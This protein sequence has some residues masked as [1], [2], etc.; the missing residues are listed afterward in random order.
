[1]TCFAVDDGQSDAI[2]NGLAFQ[3]MVGCRSAWINPH[4]D[5]G[6]DYCMSVITS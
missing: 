4:T 3:T 1:M 5:V 6:T 2:T